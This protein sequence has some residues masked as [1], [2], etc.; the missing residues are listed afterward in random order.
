[1]WRCIL[2]IIKIGL[3]GGWPPEGRIVMWHAAGVPKTPQKS[4]PAR[5]PICSVSK[6]LRTGRRSAANLLTRGEARRIGRRSHAAAAAEALK[7][8]NLKRRERTMVY[9]VSKVAPTTNGYGQCQRRFR[10]HW[11]GYRGHGRGE[12][13]NQVQCPFQLRIGQSGYGRVSDRGHP[14]W[15]RPG[16]KSD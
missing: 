10:T 3:I 5:F 1:L 15:L 6:A 14:K 8:K 2:G 16:R 4:G 12:G 9:K 13:R 7:Q 11:F